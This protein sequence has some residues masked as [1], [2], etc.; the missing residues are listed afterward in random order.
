[1]KAGNFHHTSL[2]T[3]ADPEQLLKVFNFGIQ[4]VFVTNVYHFQFPIKRKRI[5]S[6]I[7]NFYFTKFYHL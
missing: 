6:A 3:K 5:S 7:K 2:G 4:K 1:M